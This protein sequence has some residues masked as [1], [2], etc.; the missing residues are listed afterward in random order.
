MQAKRAYRA[1]VAF[2]VEQTIPGGVRALRPM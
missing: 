1:D 2:D